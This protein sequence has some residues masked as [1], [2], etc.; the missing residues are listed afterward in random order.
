MIHTVM[1]WTWLNVFRTHCFSWRCTIQFCLSFPFFARYKKKQT[2]TVIGQSFYWVFFFFF[3]VGFFPSMSQYF[4]SS[5]IVRIHHIFSLLVYTFF[6]F[7]SD[8]SL[9]YRFKIDVKLPRTPI[10]LKIRITN[11]KTIHII[12]IGIHFFTTIA[13]KQ[14]LSFSYNKTLNLSHRRIDLPPHSLNCC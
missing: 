7:S 11:Q 12:P 4:C 5:D 8:P 10:G 14:K 3:F 9:I 1:R 2:R 13:S 6:A